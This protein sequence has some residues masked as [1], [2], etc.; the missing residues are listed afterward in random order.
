MG[1]H[2]SDLERKIAKTRGISDRKFRR[3]ELYALL[4]TVAFGVFSIQFE[5]KFRLDIQRIIQPLP[6]QV[7]AEV[8][9]KLAGF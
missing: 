5:R 1:N 7:G 6:L 9:R 2:F 8:G 3:N 4:H